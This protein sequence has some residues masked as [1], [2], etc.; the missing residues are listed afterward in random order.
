MYFQQLN[1]DVKVGRTQW[2]LTKNMSTGSVV[3]W[4][5]C[6]VCQGFWVVRCGPASANSRP[7]GTREAYVWRNTS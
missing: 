5:G 6:G 3:S 7:L 1:L 4:L 2:Y